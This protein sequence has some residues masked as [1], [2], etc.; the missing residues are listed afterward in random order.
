MSR[1][2]DVCPHCKRPLERRPVQYILRRGE[3]FFAFEGVPAS[4][5]PA[6]GW[7]TVARADVT[8]MEQALATGAVLAAGVLNLP[9]FAFSEARRAVQEGK[10]AKETG[11][12]LVEDAPHT[13]LTSQIIGWAMH[14]HNEQGPGHEEAIYHRAL[15]ARMGKEQAIFEEEPNIVIET[16]DGMPVGLYRPDFVVE[17]V[18]IVEIKAHSWPLTNDEIAQVIDYFAG[19]NC[20]V[21]L[22]FN[23]GRQRLEWKRLFPP[24]R[25][26]EHRRKK[27]G[28]PLR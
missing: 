12:G 26:Q 8:V 20:N 15:A 17:D 24:K 11:P 22:L 21:A 6:C 19:T 27:W 3:Y 2:S 5:C 25:I 28:K 1:R 23:F 7:R 10:P 18:L 16:K 4:V 9:L 14:V 13:E